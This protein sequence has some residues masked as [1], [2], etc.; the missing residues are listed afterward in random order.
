MRTLAS[1][2]FYS[3]FLIKRSSRVVP[4]TNLKTWHSRRELFLREVVNGSATS[5]LHLDQPVN[6]H[7]VLLLCY[8]GI[9]LYRSPH[10]FLIVFLLAFCCISY[11]IVMLMAFI[12]MYA[13]I[14]TMTVS[15]IH[16]SVIR[17]MQIP[18]GPTRTL[19]YWK[20]VDDVNLPTFILT[21][22]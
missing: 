2:V 1:C 22:R 20:W 12:T 16:P 14:L 6:F 7:P 15:F 9:P 3:H 4:T 13:I 21:S 17:H 5:N 10:R 19:Y 11:S 8:P 18:V